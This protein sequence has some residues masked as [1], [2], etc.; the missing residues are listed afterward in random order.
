MTAPVRVHP[1]AAAA[2]ALARADDGAPAQPGDLALIAAYEQQCQADAGRLLLDGLEWDR[3]A[4]LATQCRF[5]GP[6]GSTGPD[7][8]DCDGPEVP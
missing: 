4:W 3:I 7:C 1:L 6:E 5:C 8:G 2:D